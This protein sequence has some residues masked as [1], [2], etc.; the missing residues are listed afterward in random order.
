MASRRGKVFRAKL[1]SLP[2]EDALHE[3]SEHD[4]GRSSCSTLS[5]KADTCSTACQTQ[6][7]ALPVSLRRSLPRNDDEETEEDLNEWDIDRVK[8]WALTVFDDEEV[9]GKFE[10]EEIDGKTLQSDNSYRPVKEQLGI[11]NNWGKN[12]FSLQKKR[13]VAFSKTIWPD[14]KQA[15]W[16]RRN[17]ANTK[18]LLE[19]AELLSRDDTYAFPKAGLGVKAIEEIIRKHMQERQRKEHDPLSSSENSDLSRSSNS[20]TSSAWE[21]KVRTYDSYFIDDLTLM[22]GTAVMLTWFGKTPCNDIRLADFK[23]EAKVLELS[24]LHNKDKNTFMKAVASCLI[25]KKKV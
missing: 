1:P 24:L 20:P 18:K 4:D 8:R 7:Q 13:I 6:S 10:N 16:F 25:N 21:E 9:A 19:V 22:S 5:V 14:D 23:R 2:D 17:T 15:P 3:T 11:S 12:G